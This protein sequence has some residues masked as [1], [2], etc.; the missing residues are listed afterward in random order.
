[1][2]SRT[3]QLPTP[4]KGASSAYNRQLAP[5]L[6]LSTLRAMTSAHQAFHSASPAALKGW[7]ESHGVDTAQ[8]G[9]GQAKTLEDLHEETIKGESVL[10]LD[11]SQ[12]PRPVRVVHVLNLYITNEEDKVLMEASQQL[13][14]GRIR[15]RNL[16]LS[17]KLLAGES[18]QDAVPRAVQE[19]LGTV[20]RNPF[21]MVTTHDGSYRQVVDMLQSPS[22][23][24]LMT[25][26][27]THKVRAHV[28]GLPDT[29]FTTE[30]QRPAGV[31]KTS[32]QWQ[33]P[34]AADYS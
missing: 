24:G 13:P 21:L 26:Y 15:H 19:E 33:D 18:W 3:A 25:Q 30:E 20:L 34:A 8:Y 17:E 11:N 14:D 10:T 7:L 5:A 9:T 31:M 32:W 28:P 23:P 27:V 4:T 16:P 2:L 22:Y 12:P 6:K 1:M 29:S